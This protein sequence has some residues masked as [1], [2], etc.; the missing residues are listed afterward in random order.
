MRKPVQ[1]LAVFLFFAGIS[2]TIDRLLYQPILG[3]VLNVFNRYV[4]PHIAVL[5]GYEV[6]ANL[7]VAV[8]GV[9]L[10][11]AAQRIPEDSPSA[12]P[13]IDSA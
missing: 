8:M 1:I 3:P 7:L 5:H 2:G 4:I 6:F 11:V 9:V 12:R 13:P 10:A